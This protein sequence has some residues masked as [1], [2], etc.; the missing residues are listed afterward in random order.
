M[1]YEKQLVEILTKAQECGE[2]I[3]IIVRYDK[4]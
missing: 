3:N 1:Q 2:E 4:D